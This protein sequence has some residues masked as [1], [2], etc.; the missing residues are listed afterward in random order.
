MTFGVYWLLPPFVGWYLKLVAVVG[1][2]GQ[3]G[4]LSG[5]GWV[6]Q[7]WCGGGGGFSDCGRM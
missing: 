1:H 5:K 2:L 6:C 7:G 4:H 3:F